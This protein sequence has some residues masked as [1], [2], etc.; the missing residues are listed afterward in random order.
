MEKIIIIKGVV[1]CWRD[2]FFCLVSPALRHHRGVSSVVQDGR[3]WKPQLLGARSPASPFPLDLGLRLSASC[4]CVKETGGARCLPSSQ[5]AGARRLHPRSAG[6]S[7]CL[8][9]PQRGS[10]G[11]GAMGKVLAGSQGAPPAMG[12][13]A[14]CPSWAVPTLSPPA[15]FQHLQA[16]GLPFPLEVV[17]GIWEKIRGCYV[18]TSDACI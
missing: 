5:K 3:G 18:G 6:T 1:P 9:P 7:P 14:S 17:Q 4:V 16:R 11:R 15:L 10:P 8:E 13:G 12:I 2:F